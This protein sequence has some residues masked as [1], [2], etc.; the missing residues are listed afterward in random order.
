MTFVRLFGHGQVAAVT[1]IQS[2]HRATQIRIIYHEVVAAVRRA[3]QGLAGLAGT[4]DSV[5]T[6]MACTPVWNIQ[7]QW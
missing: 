4:I 5:T 1:K 7:E 3:R 6:H 2:V